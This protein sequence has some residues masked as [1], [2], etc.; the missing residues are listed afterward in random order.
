MIKKLKDKKG[1]TVIIIVMMLAILF[2][3]IIAGVVDLTNIFKIQKRM[4]TVLNASVKSASSRVDW[5]QVPDGH[6][7]IDVNEAE[8]AF[9]DIFNSNMDIEL[10]PD[11]SI[12]KGKS[13]N[14]KN[15]IKVYFDV[16]ND[17]HEGTYVS[18]PESGTIPKEITERLFYTEADRP[19]AIAI[20]SVQYKTSFVLGGRTLDIIQFASSQL[21]ISPD[22]GDTIE[23]LI[24]GSEKP[25]GTAIINPSL[26]DI[27]KDY[28]ANNSYYQVTE[29]ADI[30]N[31]LPIFKV[32]K[33]SDLSSPIEIATINIGVGEVYTASIWVKV[34]PH[35]A[36]GP[37]SRL[38]FS[39]NSQVLAST[40]TKKVGEWVRL[41]VTFYNK[42]GANIS[43]A[44]VYYYP[45]EKSNSV[46]YFSFPKLEKGSM[47]TD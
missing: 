24:D 12:Y 40:E 19:T 10:E 1:G 35:S 42:T 4:K 9:V 5:D 38:V 36:T 41:K 3:V 30:L 8:K 32:T 33:K 37:T 45:A 13:K 14:T 28:T 2:P 25:E 15:S 6:F 11:G 44:K 17:R 21:N 47:A 20:A 29:T 34:N 7:R 43:N 31:D 26:I 18:F 27:E 22:V 16:Y 46:T 23:S 39:R